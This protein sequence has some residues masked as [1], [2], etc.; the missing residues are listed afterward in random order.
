MLCVSQ[1]DISALFTSKMKPKKKN[2]VA[3]G[4]PYN[5]RPILTSIKVMFDSYYLK[6]VIT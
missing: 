3:M 5:N 2:K 6:I 1:N 4:S